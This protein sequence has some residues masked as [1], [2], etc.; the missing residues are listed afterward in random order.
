[1]QNE[2]TDSSN[3]D[4]V[5]ARVMGHGPVIPLKNIRVHSYSMC[6]KF[7][8]NINCTYIDTCIHLVYR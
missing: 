1:M 5:M 3:L 2:S 6:I 4:M 7:F 8:N